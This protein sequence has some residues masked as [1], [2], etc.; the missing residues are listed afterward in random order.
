MTFTTS[1]VKMNKAQRSS[2]PRPETQSLSGEEPGLEPRASSLPSDCPHCC[3][4]S[5]KVRGQVDEQESLPHCVS[6]T[7]WGRPRPSALPPSPG[8]TLTLLYT[9]RRQ[10]WRE[11]EFDVT[12]ISPQRR[13][14]SACKCLGSSEQCRCPV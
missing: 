5:Y 1:H 14:T 4:D 7:S 13:R 9:I 2:L 8:V 12:C 11:A 6:R 10:G 3:G